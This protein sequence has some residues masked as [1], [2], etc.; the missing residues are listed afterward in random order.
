MIFID[1]NCVNFFYETMKIRAVFHIHD[2]VSVFK[3][4]YLFFRQSRATL[5][6]TKYCSL[7][8]KG[9]GCRPFR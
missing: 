2:K 9:F 1:L 4:F 8:S 7:Y 6:P 3:H 5:T